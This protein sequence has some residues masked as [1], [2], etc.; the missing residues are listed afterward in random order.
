M[1]S[2][3]LQNTTCPV[4]YVDYG[5]DGCH[6]NPHPIVGCVYQNEEEAQKAITFLEEKY[7]N[8]RFFIGDDP[9]N[10]SLASER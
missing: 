10:S 3:G 4:I 2:V 6:S 8:S 7:P 9:F 5:I 1:S